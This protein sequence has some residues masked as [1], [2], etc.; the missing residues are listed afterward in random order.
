MRQPVFLGFRADRPASSV[1]REVPAEAPAPSIY[2][3]EP[4]V[5]LFRLT[6]TEKVYWPADGYT[7]ADLAD[8]YRAIAPVLLPYLR[9]RPLSLHRH[10]DG[11]GGEGFFQKDVSKSPPPPFV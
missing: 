11:V 3:E 5:P 10:P 9:Y 8:Y 4:P 6:N 2:P 1:R 7:K